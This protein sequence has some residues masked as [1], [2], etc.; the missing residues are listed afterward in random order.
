MKPAPLMLSLLLKVISW[1][2]E[3]AIDLITIGPEAPLVDGLVDSLKA[4]GLR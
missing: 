1:C 2:K 3:Q 4:A